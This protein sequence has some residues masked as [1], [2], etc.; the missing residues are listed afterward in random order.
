MSAAVDPSKVVQ[1]LDLSLKLRK[2]RFEMLPLRGEGAPFTELQGRLPGESTTPA[3]LA[4]LISSI[5]E[6]GILQPIL[7]E[8]LTADEPGGRPGMRLATG[9]R[10]LRACLWGA[11]HR[12]DNPHFDA[13]P[14]VVCPGPLSEE[15]RR[16]WQLVENL[17]REDLQP[18]E[19]AAALV[20]DRCAVLVGKLLA[21]GIAV[22]AEAYAIDDPMERF[23]ALERHRGNN[24]QVAAPWAEVLER[25]GLQCSPRKA[26]ELVRAFAE[27]PREISEE[28]DEAKVSLH[29][30]IRFVELCRGRAAAANDIWAEVKKDG[31][32]KLLPA[33]LASAAA[34]EALS[35]EAAVGHA[36]QLHLEANNSRAAKLRSVP[37]TDLDNEAA[38]VDEVDGADRDVVPHHEAI[39]RDLRPPHS[40]SD[41]TAG[42]NELVPADVVAAALSGLRE[43]ATAL[44]NGQRLSKHDRASLQLLTRQL[45]AGVEAA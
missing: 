36:E 30:R 27:M 29:T 13:V 45:D 40:S 34:D 8:E 12:P 32:T 5:S 37:A 10:R 11:T 4:D 7:V 14:A 24:K 43:L 41:T 15:E 38:E 3:A 1:Q 33:A 2:R 28:M 35:G 42:E 20:L 39:P 18:G 19:L 9:E 16:I 17:A 21:A 22:P 31:R 25:L 6:V 26:R 23:R 44:A